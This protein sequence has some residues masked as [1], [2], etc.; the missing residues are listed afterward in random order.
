MERI[1]LDGRYVSALSRRQGVGSMPLQSLEAHLY[2]EGRFHYST[3][4]KQDSYSLE[5]QEHAK[6]TI[7]AHGRPQY[8]HVHVTFRS[9][10]M[11]VLRLRHRPRPLISRLS[12]PQYW[13][14]KSH[15]IRGIAQ[16]RRWGKSNSVRTQNITRLQRDCS[17]IQ[18]KQARV[19]R[20]RWYV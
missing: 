12:F 8:R 17:R 15:V 18:S 11:S 4:Y 19:I 2:D 5:T 3:G 9:F 1:Q 14:C 13:P 7:S 20:F 6:K 10:H 16:F